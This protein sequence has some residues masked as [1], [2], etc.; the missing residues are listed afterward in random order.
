MNKVM[1]VML[2][3][4]QMLF[5]E[6]YAKKVIRKNALVLEGIE[7]SKQIKDPETPASSRQFFE[8][9]L[10]RVMNSIRT[11]NRQVPACGITV[12]EV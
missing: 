8:R 1:I 9:E 5:P 12:R 3:G 6:E 7:Y 4:S 11:I 2:D 10:K